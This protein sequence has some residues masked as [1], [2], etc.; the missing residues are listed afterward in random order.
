MIH[1][2]EGRADHGR[3]GGQ[4]VLRDGHGWLGL[5]S[6]RPE[7]GAPDRRLDVNRV[8]ALLCAFISADRWYACSLIWYSPFVFGSVWVDAKGADATVMPLWKFFV[9]PLRELITAWLLA[10]LMGRRAASLG[11]VLWLAFCV[12][13]LSGALVFDGMRTH[14][15]HL[16]HATA[17]ER[18]TSR[19]HMRLLPTSAGRGSYVTFR[20]PKPSHC[21]RHEVRHD[22]MGIA[23]S[24]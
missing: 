1:E 4:Q 12:V 23:Q 20:G 11:L 24:D 6:Q 19:W 16:A 7:V 14:S 22:Q 10:W 18:V 21:W 2:L 8:A 3:H 17:S 13:Q 5:D 15:Q 9:A